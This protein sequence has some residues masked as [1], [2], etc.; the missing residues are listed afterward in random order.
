MVIL[1]LSKMLFSRMST[2]LDG[3]V[4][5]N[6]SVI[7]SSTLTPRSF[8]MQVSLLTDTRFIFTFIV[9]QLMP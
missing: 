3:L 2:T 1:L 7:C 4:F 6:L 8:V 5:I 9:S